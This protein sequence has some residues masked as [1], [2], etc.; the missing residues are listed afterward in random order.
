M[1]AQFINKHADTQ[2]KTDLLFFWS[3]YPNA[4]FTLGAIARGPVDCTRKADMEEAL[5][6]FAKDQFIEKHVQ[7]GVLFYSLT[8]N[9]EKREPFLKLSAC[10]RGHLPTSAHARRQKLAQ[11]ISEEASIV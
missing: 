7:Q 2:L 9:P 6:S 11:L 10:S 1:F 4:K 3:R 8:T 5:E